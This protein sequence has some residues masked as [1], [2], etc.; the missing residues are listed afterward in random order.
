MSKNV[1]ILVVKDANPIKKPLKI[2]AAEERG[3]TILSIEAFK[4]FF[5][6]ETF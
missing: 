3:I 6:L 4:A 2:I 5:K 1:N